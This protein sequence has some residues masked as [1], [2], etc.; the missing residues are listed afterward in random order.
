MELITKK[1][2]RYQK[3]KYIKIKNTELVVSNIAL[4]C[5]RLVKPVEE[6]EEVVKKAIDLGI[7]FFDHADIYGGGRSEKLF[8]EVIKRN[9]EL[10]S[11]MIIQTKCGIVPGVCYNSSKE[12]ILKQVNQS[13][14]YLQT[15]YI[16]VL[17]LH[18]PDALVDPK[19]VAEA[20]DEL[21]LSGK[22][23]YFGVSNMNALQIELLKK[24]IKQ[25]IVFNQLQFNVVNSSMI[26]SG[27]HVNMDDNQAIDRDGSLLDYCRI[28]DITIQPWSILQAS[29]QKGSYLNHPD[30]VALNNKLNELAN[31]YAVTP[32]CIAVAWI[33]RHP[34]NMQ[35]IAGTTSLLHLEELVKANQISLT[36]EEWYQLYLSTGKT[37]P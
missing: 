35:P 1:I 37:L 16:D 12:H 9:P 19:E 22:V 13:L 31:K 18:R 34:A 15:D 4:G 6:V 27:I 10:R 29:W 14:E 26:D 21:Y 24:E 17:L 28:Q 7:N 33:L 23:K 2:R 5:M 8:G 20:F 25:P 11:K 3:M 36:R 32:A 30:Y